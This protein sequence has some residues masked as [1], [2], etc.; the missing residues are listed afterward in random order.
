MENNSDKLFKRMAST[1]A[2]L[3]GQAQ[4][5]DH[6]L[7]NA[8][9]T[10]YITP[11]M[12]GTIG[13]IIKKKKKRTTSIW[14]STIA[15]AA[16]F[17]IAVTALSGLWAKQGSLETEDTAP[18][19]QDSVVMREGFISMS[20]DTGPQYHISDTDYDNG[21]SIYYVDNTALDNIVM[22]LEKSDEDFKEY[23]KLT[24]M[25]VAGVIAYGIY[26]ADYSLL[27]FERGGIYY[28]LT[29]GYDIRTLIDFA[30]IIIRQLT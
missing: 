16:C 28:T 17:V 5:R 8:Q 7:L 29:C 1:Y 20:F 30:E 13:E 11:R 19:D 25:S 26:R 21:K 12:D 14:I 15:A 9:N 22:I 4:K 24:R 3:Y 10:R 23:Q 18:G 2:D 27:A 6:E